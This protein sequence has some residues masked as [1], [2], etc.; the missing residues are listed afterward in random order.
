[1]GALSRWILRGKFACVCVEVDLHKPPI[2]GYHLRG[3][4][5]RLQYEGLHE[6]CSEC[7]CYGHRLLTCT[8]KSSMEK[9]SSASTAN[10]AK[11]GQ[12]GTAA[13]TSTSVGEEANF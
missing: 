12:G 2:S 7:G 8:L 3:D 11:D 6:I 13:I 10:L 5:W 1:M 4:F 9:E